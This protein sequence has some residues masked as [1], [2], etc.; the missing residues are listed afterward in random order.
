M[1]NTIIKALFY[2]KVGTL[3]SIKTSKKYLILANKSIK[4]EK[5]LLKN[6]NENITKLLDEYF[7]LQNKLESEIIDHYYIEGF[8]IGARV[9]FE[10]AQNNNS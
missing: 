8:K 4:L 5:L 10:C 9:A 6:C 7:N 2:E 3:N 1:Q